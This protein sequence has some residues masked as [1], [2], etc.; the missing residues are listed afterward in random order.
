MIVKIWPIKADYKGAKGKVGGHQG[1]KNAVEYIMDPEKVI[2]PPDDILVHKP[3]H[4]DDVLSGGGINTELDFHRLISYVANEDKTEGSYISTYRCRNRNV[5]VDFQKAAEMLA[6]KSGFKVNPERGVMAYHMVQSFPENLDITNEEVHECGMELVRKLEKYQ[7][8]ICSHVHPVLDEEGEVHG[9]A[10][11]NHIVFSAYIHPDF[12][13]PK[14]GPCKYN[15]CKATYRQLQIY[16]DE[17]AIAHGLPIIR[18]ADMERTYSWKES[19]EKNKG[20]SW[21]ERVR[22]DIKMC[23]RVAADWDEFLKLMKQ[24][25]YTLQVKKKVTYTTP[26]GHAVRGSTLGYEFTKEA[27]DLY[28]AIRD[29]AKDVIKQDLWANQEPILSDFAYKYKGK[30]SVQIPLGPQFEENRQFAYVP[31]SKDTK[32]DEDALRSYMDMAQLY[33]IY[34]E[35]GEVVAVAS[36][37]EILRSI[38][39]L[40]DEGRMRYREHLR[41]KENEIREERY[42]RAVQREEE[43]ERKERFYQNEEFKNS[44]TG[45]IYKCEL[46]DENGRRRTLIEL[47]FVLALVI[48][49]KESYLWVPREDVSKEQEN[50]VFFTSTDRKLQLMVDSIELSRQEEIN[51]P[52]QLEKRLNIVGAAYSRT[53]RAYHNTAKEGERMEPVADAVNTYRKTQ[54]IAE[55]IAAISDDA[56]KIELYRKYKMELDQF[57][58]A[59]QM[60]LAKGITKDED[61][62][63]FEQRYAKICADVQELDARLKDHAEHYR[64]LKKLEYSLQLAQEQKFIYGPAYPGVENQFK[65]SDGQAGSGCLWK[66]IERA[67]RLQAQKKMNIQS[68]GLVQKNEP[69]HRPREK[70]F[71]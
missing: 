41:M 46:Y 59:K 2:V 55:S 18:Q 68:V 11:H 17:I 37:I 43:K 60:L 70:E 57:K 67:Q 28:W 4:E 22:M 25:G 38:E 13:D 5:A 1:I 48:L 61:I 10:K 71:R 40:K 65:E 54:K 63:D 27:L 66:N 58:S 36:G 23:R 49:D 32:A 47:I 30:L 53:K 3:Y 33:D 69:E 51:T 35:Q 14:G 24:E 15:D 20:T 8:L 6:L 62:I 34:N 9:R 29:H 45:G 21:K 39:D 42:R 12:Y 56:K 26:D 52:V 16:N 50:E 7:A 31:I 64:R 44:R 19:D